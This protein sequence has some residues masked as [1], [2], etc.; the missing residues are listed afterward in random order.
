MEVRI[1]ERP[2]F[3]VITLIASLPDMGRVGGLVPRFLIEH[4]KAKM[5]AEIYHFEKPYVICKDGLI[6]HYPNVYR[7]YYSR[8]ASLIIFTGEEQPQNVSS[9]YEICNT[10]IDVAKKSGSVKRV[11]TAGGY[12]MERLEQEPR[13]FGVANMPH[14]LD[15]LDRIGIREIGREVSSITW[16]NGL[17]LGVALTRNIEGIGLYGELDNP[18]I[19]QPKA[20]RAVLKAIFTLLSLPQIDALKGDSSQEAIT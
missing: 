2:S 15:E 6:S 9:L 19:P 4:L 11:Y 14:L 1:S 12:F 18:Q 20:A 7:M 3:D 17:I 8:K 10:V 13:V 5:F 16:F